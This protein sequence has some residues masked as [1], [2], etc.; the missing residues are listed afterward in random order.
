MT[1]N[2]SILVV[3]DDP[4]ALRYIVKVLEFERWTDEWRTL[5]DSGKWTEA[6]DYGLAKTGRIVI[7]DHGSEFWF[8]NIKIRKIHEDEGEA[9]E[10]G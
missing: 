10:E 5:R 1:K 3:D 6:P 9:G 2:V 4:V 8:R 7:Q